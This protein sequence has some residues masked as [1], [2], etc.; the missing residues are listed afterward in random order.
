MTEPTPSRHLKQTVGLTGVVMF[1]AGSAIGVSIFSVLQPAAQVAGSGLLIAMLI[2]TIPM[3]LFA[4]SYAFM[5]SAL[6][7]SGASYEWPR[8]FIHPFV[9]FMIAWLR[10]VA[11]VGAVIVLSS[12]LVSY[13]GMAFDL[14]RKPTMAAAITIAFALNYFGVSIASG[15]Q[16]VLMGL[17]LIVL[18]A[19]TFTG[20]PMTTMDLIQP[21]VGHGWVAILACVP[22]M[23]SLFLGIEAAVEIGEEVK[24]PQ[25]TLPRGIVLAV[26]LT[27]VVYG[28]VAVTAL[29][30]IGPDALAN[31]KTPLLD[32]AKVPLG[33]WAAPVII[34]AATISIMKS[35]NGLALGFSRSLFAMGREGALPS[36]FNKIHPK[37]GTPYM[38]I[39]IGW[40]AGLAGIFLPDDLVFLLL[41]VNIPT[42]LKYMAC[43]ISATNLVKHHPELHANAG[44]KWK[45]SS[46]LWLG[47]LGAVCAVVVILAGIE[48]DVRPYGLLAVWAVIGVIYWAVRSRIKQPRNP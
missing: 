17:L 13:L 2:A 39:L 29:G 28:L 43:S 15:I 16:T 27:L 41:A 7:T 40:G 36:V 9:G 46:V 34:G 19:F 38:A 35:L 24:N 30:L 22:L 4:S 11:N 12:V 10:I 5:G 21:I 23:I 45:K 31:T 3:V 44:L 37:F 18:A 25:K 14:P 26:L 8:R 32:A 48:A 6:P 33:P 1:G 42:M 20:L 47:Y